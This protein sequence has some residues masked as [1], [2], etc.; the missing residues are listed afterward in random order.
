MG[1]ERNY[2][3]IESRDVKSDAISDRFRSNSPQ[4]HLQIIPIGTFKK[5]ALSRNSL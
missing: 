3:V 2:Y 5:S 4:K 1:F